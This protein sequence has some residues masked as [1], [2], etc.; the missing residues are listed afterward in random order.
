MDTSKRNSLPS[1]KFALPSQ[2]KYPINDPAHAANA[3]ARASQQEKAGN[4][5][6]LTKNEI[7]AKANKVLGRYQMAKKS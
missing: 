2:R 7:F 4:I 5:S 3:K 1:Y 6:E